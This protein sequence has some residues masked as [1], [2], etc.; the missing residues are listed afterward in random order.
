[1]GLPLPTVR[2]GAEDVAGTGKSRRSGAGVLGLGLVV[3]GLTGL[4]V[5][6]LLYA[7]A[8]LP[9]LCVALGVVLFPMAERLHQSQSG[10][11][12]AVSCR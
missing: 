3:L 1:M 10:K 6:T 8:G 11:H 4:A 5:P 12:A 7:V 9:G 2:P